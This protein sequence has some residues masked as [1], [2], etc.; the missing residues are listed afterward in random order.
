YSQRDNWGQ[1]YLY[2]LTTGRIKHKITSGEGP[3]TQ[4]VQVDEKNR[5]LWFAARGREK[6]QD[7]YFAHF[8]RIGLDGKNV[9]SLTPDDGD[10]TIQLSPSRR[11]LIDTYSRLDVPPVGTLRDANGALVMPLEKADISKLLATGWKPPIPITM[12]AQDGV[13]DIYGLMF[14]P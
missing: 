11:F 8:Y 9:V 2:D 4:I 1:L 13:T 6:G 7:P 3:V 5:I 12:K 14:R 10:H